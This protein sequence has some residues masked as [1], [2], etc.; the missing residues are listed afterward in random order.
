MPPTATA[1]RADSE[2]RVH[3]YGWCSGRRHG[4]LG[5]LQ[6]DRGIKSSAAWRLSRAPQPGEATTVRTTIRPRRATMA[7]GEGVWSQRRW[8]VPV[9]RKGERGARPTANP[10]SGRVWLDGEH[11]SAR[12]RACFD[13]RAGRLG[14][15]LGG[16]TGS[17]STG[18]RAAWLGT[19]SRGRGRG[20]QRSDLGTTWASPRRS[21]LESGGGI[22]AGGGEARPPLP[23]APGLCG[24]DGAIAPQAVGA[25][26]ARSG[27][28][29]DDATGRD[30]GEHPGDVRAV[31]ASPDRQR[32]KDALAVKRAEGVR[33]GR[34]RTLAPEV[35]ERV[36]RM[37]RRGTSLR[38]IAARLNTD[39]V[40]TAARRGT[41]AR[42]DRQRRSAKRQSGTGGVEA[43]RCSPQSERVVQVRGTQIK[44]QTRVLIARQSPIPGRPV[45]GTAVTRWFRPDGEPV[46]TCV[47]D[48][49]TADGYAVMDCVE[50]QLLVLPPASK[51]SGES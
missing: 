23:L 36:W 13:R 8:C 47:L 7:N 27:R 15:G 25:G 20:L 50:A 32:T 42:L 5:A 1:R 6:W 10:V 4:S 24:G 19:R 30:D 16:P 35:V 41:L 28:G 26:R 33:L 21:V 17:D 49:P 34:P 14:G 3:G 40:P 39:G 12:L 9:Q 31:R 22:C 45:I 37:H 2:R 29:H 46:Y 18:L 48:A 43:G 38:R 51:V 44:Y 11:A